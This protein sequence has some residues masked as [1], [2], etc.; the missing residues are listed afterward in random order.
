MPQFVQ[1]KK[2]T[3]KRLFTNGIKVSKY[4][5]NFINVKH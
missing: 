1:M 2:C 3:E 4:S 5:F